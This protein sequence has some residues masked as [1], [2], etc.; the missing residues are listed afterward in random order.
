MNLTT[1]N[2]R[3]KLRRE[4]LNISQDKLAEMLGYRDK[5][6]ICRIETGKNQLRLD[7]VRDFS[8][9]LKTSPAYLMGWVDN[10]ELTHEETLQLEREGKIKIIAADTIS[11]SPTIIGTMPKVDPLQQKRNKLADRIKNS[12]YTDAELDKIE[13]MLDIVVSR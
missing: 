7:R 1:S 10:P 4:Q 13:Q 3:I 12:D 11:S 8:K 9:A 5:S 6:A 2:I